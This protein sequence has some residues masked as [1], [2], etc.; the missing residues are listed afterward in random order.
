[1]PARAQDAYGDAFWQYR[2]V[3]GVDYNTCHYESKTPNAIVY[4]S[5]H[6]R[7]AKGPWTLKLIV[8]WLHV[9]GPAV[10]LDGG[11]SGSVASGAARDVSGIGDI[12]LS[13]TDAV[14]KFADHGVFIDL[15]ARLKVPTARF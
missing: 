5:A 15:T 14:Q 9:S 6:L 1:M 3:V 10:L 8:P 12:S 2:A 7:A 11:A 13:A 4:S